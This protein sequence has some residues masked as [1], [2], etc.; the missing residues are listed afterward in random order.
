[1]YCIN[2]SFQFSWFCPIDCFLQLTSSV[3][4]IVIFDIVCLGSR[5]ILNVYLLYSRASLVPFK[6]YLETWNSIILY[7]M[8]DRNSISC[9]IV[10]IS[11]GFNM[12]L[13]TESHILIYRFD[14]LNAVFFRVFDIE[15]FQFFL[16]FFW[17]FQHCHIQYD[18]APLQTSYISL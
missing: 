10:E 16:I 14:W 3:I 15:T 4:I 18:L 2:L 9:L 6:V 7:S 5:W 8:T 1:M 11:M 17:H 13:N 12:E